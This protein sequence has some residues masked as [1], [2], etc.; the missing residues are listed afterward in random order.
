MFFLDL[1]DSAEKNGGWV[2]DRQEVRKED[3]C[4][5]ASDMTCVCG[6]HLLLLTRDMTQKSTYTYEKKKKEEGRLL[7]HHAL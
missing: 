1:D 4:E 6:P 7:I 3:V 5:V 2:E